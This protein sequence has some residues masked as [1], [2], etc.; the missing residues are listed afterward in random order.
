MKSV[1]GL[2]GGG[3]KTGDLVIGWDPLPAQEHN[4]PGVYYRYMRDDIFS[5][6]E[7]KIL[8]TIKLTLYK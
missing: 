7:T 2:Q 3:G 1:T 6:L 8:T 4:A 5:K